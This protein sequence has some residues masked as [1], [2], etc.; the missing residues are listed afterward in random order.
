[1]TQTKP[2]TFRVFPRKDGKAFL[3]VRC[4]LNLDG[5]CK[6]PLARKRIP[7]FVWQWDG[8]IQTP[9]IEPSIACRMSRCGKHF[10]ITKGMA[11]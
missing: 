4:H 2:I 10:T 3:L 6:F 11:A 7:E 5:E 8:N 9:T 1:M